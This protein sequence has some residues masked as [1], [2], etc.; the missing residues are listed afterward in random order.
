MPEIK[1]C[2]DCKFYRKPFLEPARCYAR[3][4]IEPPKYNLLT[5][6]I[7][8]T[9]RWRGCEYSRDNEGISDCGFIARYFKP[10]LA[11]WQRIKQLVGV[12]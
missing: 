8:R 3:E 5:G 4:L 2:K 6:K 7:I 9:P 1:F 12:K 10:R 11:L